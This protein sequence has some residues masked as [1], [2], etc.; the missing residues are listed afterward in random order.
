[1]FNLRALPRIGAVALTA[2]SLVLAL[3]TSA[4][5]S[6]AGHFGKTDPTYNGVF[7]HSLA[8]MGLTAIDA[9]LPSG[10]VTWLLNQQ[11]AD[12]SFESYRA[13]T[14]IPCAKSDPVNYSGPDSNSTAMAAIAL[15]F[16]GKNTQARKAIS[17]LNTIQ[18]DDFGFPYYAGGASDGN[19]TALAVRAMETVQPQDRSARVPNAKEY[20]A[21]LRL[22]CTS[23]GGLAYQKGQPAN[24]MA[25][26]DALLTLASEFPVQPSA[27]LATNPT[28]TSTAWVNVASYLAQEIMK[29][30]GIPSA[31]GSGFDY[32]ST[33]SAVLGLIGLDMGS[34]AVAQATATLK[35]D[36]RAFALPDG[37]PNPGALGI[38]MMV[39]EATNSSATNFGGVNLVTEL[40]NSVRSS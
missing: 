20:L 18:G 7:R 25:S 39:A 1:M 4:Q 27:N 22:K 6:D 30:G 10:S 38:L 21:S 19:S 33:A 14:S 31:M 24:G 35:R 2:A 37:E 17:W 34:A 5:A 40:R 8:I 16:A 32:N 13:D 12:G 3:P 9:P 28:C 29:S 26:A 11:C 15:S 36:A 23:G